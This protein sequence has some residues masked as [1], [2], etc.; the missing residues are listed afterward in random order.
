MRGGHYVYTESESGQSGRGSGG[1]RT[2][3]DGPGTG[4]DAE[5]VPAG[6]PDDLSGAAI[7]QVDAG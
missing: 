2:R 4:R 6:S 5:L 1:S 7:A 3:E